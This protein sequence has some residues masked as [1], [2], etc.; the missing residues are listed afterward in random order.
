MRRIAVLAA[1][2]ALA[3]AACGGDD[4]EPAATPAAT[5]AAGAAGAT[6]KISADPSGAKKFTESALTTDA[7]NVDG[8]VRQPVSLPHA[9]DDRGQRRR[10]RPRRRS[11]AT[12]R[13]RSPSTCK[14]GEYTY[15]CPVGDHRAAGMEGKL[16]VR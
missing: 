8:R 13:R 5:E 12:T 2:A 6:L 11:P 4:N 1:G 9:V 3:L 16:T 7:G 10:R 15:Y 14:P